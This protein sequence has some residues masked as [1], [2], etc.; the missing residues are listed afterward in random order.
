MSVGGTP[1]SVGNAAMSVG[2]AAMGGTRLAMHC[3]E[4]SSDVGS[5]DGASER[6]FYSPVATSVAKPFVSAIAAYGAIK[7]PLRYAAHPHSRETVC[8]FHFLGYYCCCGS[9]ANSSPSR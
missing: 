6:G 3:A 7:A 4:L 2:D 9:T 8:P 1:M 5:A